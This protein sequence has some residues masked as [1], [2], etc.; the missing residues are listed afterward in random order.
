MG[1]GEIK[2]DIELRPASEKRGDIKL[3]LMMEKASERDAELK[4]AKGDEGTRHSEPE[5]TKQGSARESNRG[6]PVERDEAERG[7]ETAESAGEARNRSAK[8]HEEMEQK[9][10]SRE[11]LQPHARARPS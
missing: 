1:S 2:G 10:R 6:R 5:L 3:E 7:T 11:H 4:T 8:W 9:R